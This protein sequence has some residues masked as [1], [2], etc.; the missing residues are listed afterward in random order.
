[1]KSFYSNLVKLSAVI[2]FLFSTNMFSQNIGDALRLGLPGLGVS[3]R[4]LGMGDSYI[5]LSDDASAAYYNPAGLG[6][7]KRIEFSG[8]LDYNKFQ[9]S[10]T[11]FGNTTNESNTATRLNRISLAV[12][13]PTYRGSLVFGI[14]YHTS[15][16]LTGAMKFD[17]FNSGNNSLIQDLLSTNIPYDLYLTDTLNQTPINGKL[18]QSGSI[19]S[20]GSVNNWAFTGAIEVYKNFFVG[21]NLD[22]ITGSYTSNNDYYEDDTQGNYQG[23]TAAGEPQTKDFLTFYLNRI[24]DWDIKG[25]DAKLG[26][27]YQMNNFARFGATVQ[28]PKFHTIKEKFTV[29]GRSDFGTGTSYSLLSSDYSDQVEYDIVTPFE[30]GMGFSVNVYGLILSGQATMI[31]YSQM[32]FKN[33]KG[34]STQYV[35]SLNKDITTNLGSV[36]NLNAGAEYTIPVIGLRIR[37]GFILQPSAYKND[38]SEYD[39]KFITAGIG[40]LVD[41]TVSMDIGFA[42]GWWKDYGDNYGYN[43]SRTHQDIKTNRVIVGMTYRF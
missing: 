43:V 37:G 41:Q 34:L 21:V 5:G 6:L 2:I 1:M 42:H 35:A 32:E 36:I 10:T 33:P 31:D 11:F 40:F 15:K 7:L 26:I 18:N 12:P 16:D 4:A 29:N 24:L 8:N 30:L 22:Y 20:S 14:S 19:L 13:F 39:K 17:G 27:M 3:A 9:N 25:W 38:P 28:F 23:E